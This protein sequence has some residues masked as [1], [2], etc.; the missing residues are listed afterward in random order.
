MQLECR[1]S[2]RGGIAIAAISSILLMVCGAA[3]SSGSASHDGAA[4]GGGG[5]GAPSDAGASASTCQ[6]IRLC[7]SMCTDDACVATCVQH[8]SAD[9]QA[10]FQAVASCTQAPVADGGGGCTSVSDPTYRNCLCLA[11]CVQQP[12]CAATLDPCLGTIDDTV[13]DSCH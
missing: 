3:C 10:A 8:G 11:Q 4:G 12:P 6:Q 2:G 1:H 7:A 9:A 5:G 13:C